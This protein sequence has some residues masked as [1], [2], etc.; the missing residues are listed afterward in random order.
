M[1]QVT[2]PRVFSFL[3][4]FPRVR[5]YRP[6]VVATISQ[7]SLPTLHYLHSLHYFPFS[8][9][10]IAF[11]PFAP[12]CSLTSLTTSSFASF[13]SLR[14]SS[15]EGDDDD[16]PQD[17]DAA[18]GAPVEDSVVAA[19]ADPG[20]GANGENG[21]WEL[22]GRGKRQAG[23][24]S[25]SPSSS[26]PSS[27]AITPVPSDGADSQYHYVPATKRRHTSEMKFSHTLWLGLNSS[28]PHS[29][30]ECVLEQLAVFQAAP[31][32]IS[33]GAL[34]LIDVLAGGA[35]SEVRRMGRG[36]GGG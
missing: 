27:R 15:D 30:Y 32:V 36:D 31:P 28:E 24:G 21:G 13:R 25:L 33:A 10:R 8:L 4:D 35:K 9:S 2:P 23:N 18:P 20:G 12:C 22:G 3:S 29:S 19:Q 34:P 1:K 17:P 6:T 5:T 26:H 14:S 11:P 16:A 7:S